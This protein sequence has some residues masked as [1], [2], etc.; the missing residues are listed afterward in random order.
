MRSIGN[1]C[2]NA[3][4]SIRNMFAISQIM[5]A[6]NNNRSEST[7]AFF[8]F[9]DPVGQNR[10]ILLLFLNWNRAHKDK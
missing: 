3:I 9:G 8:G 7:V 4:L 6:I 10:Y 5:E 2:F 1:F